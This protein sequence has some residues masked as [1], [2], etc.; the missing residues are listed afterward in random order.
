M[1]KY[2]VIGATLLGL[3]A[4]GAGCAE[5][6]VKEEPSKK[7]PPAE[8]VQN[9]VDEQVAAKD[10][11]E[12]AEA[13]EE[14]AKPDVAQLG[15]SIMVGDVEVT[16]QEAVDPIVPHVDPYLGEAFDEPSQDRF[17]GVVVKLTNKGDLPFDPS[18]DG[19]A[20]L[21]MADDVPA[22][23]A[24]MTDTQPWAKYVDAKIAPG[25]SLVL[26]LPFDVPAGKLGRF[27]YSILTPDFDEVVGE[28][29]LA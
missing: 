12:A 19:T 25:D 11:L 23:D 13:G 18:M 14:A 8:Q 5:T 15:D 27:Q 29:E 17:A 1:K 7:A 28:W 10:A 4:V 9:A 21:V 6:E 26:H 2:A 16:V 22:D 24:L 3:V 20:S